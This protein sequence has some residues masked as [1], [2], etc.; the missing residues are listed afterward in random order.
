VHDGARNLAEIPQSDHYTAD[1][2]GKGDD[3]GWTIEPVSS[4]FQVRKQT[5]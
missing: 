2:R 4:I 1:I 5:L 3:L